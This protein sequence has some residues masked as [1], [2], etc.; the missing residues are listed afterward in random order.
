MDEV[1]VS[2]SRDRPNGKRL[3]L[4]IRKLDRSAL[5]TSCS[6]RFSL[7]TT[8]WDDGHPLD[9]RLADLLTEHGVRATFYVPR[10]SQSFTMSPAQVRELSTRF[11]IGAHTLGHVFLD[12]CSDGQARE[13]ICGSRQWVEDVTGKP[14]TM[15]CPP[16]GK[17]SSRHLRMMEEAGFAGFRSVELLSLDP[18]RA[19]GQQLLELPT[20]VQAHPH[21]ALSYVRNIARRRAWRNLWRYVRYGATRPDWAQLARALAEECKR[22]GGVFHLWGHS[23]EIEANQQ[24][25]RLRD[26]LSWLGTMSGQGANATNGELCTPREPS[27]TNLKPARAT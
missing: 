16:G 13:E 4:P 19:C 21:R 18:P 20:S 12:S 2:D 1:D 9:L 6:S 22:T 8:S 15:F 26:V 5:Q 23:W 25:D 14:C 3:P 17:F 7:I 10:R 24:W 11:E 27:K